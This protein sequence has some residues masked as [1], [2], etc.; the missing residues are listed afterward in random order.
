MGFNLAYKGLNVGFEFFLQFLSEI[1]LILRRIRSIIIDVHL[2]ACKVTV[3]S[4]P[5]LM[6][7]GFSRQ[8]FGKY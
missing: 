2:S 4:C 6:K 3:I 7:L 1:F 5:I 8:A